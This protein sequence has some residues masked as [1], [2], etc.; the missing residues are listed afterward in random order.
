FEDCTLHCS[1]IRLHHDMAHT[2][3]TLSLH[4]D[5]QHQ[6]HTTHHLGSK[7]CLLEIQTESVSA[8]SSQCLHT[9]HI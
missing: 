2:H 6:H 1:L 3:R 7:F 9:P 5:R 4:S 8:L